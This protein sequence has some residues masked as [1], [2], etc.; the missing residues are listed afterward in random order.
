MNVK[1]IINEEI[2][3]FTTALSEEV[4][5]DNFW[6]WFRNSKIVDKSGKPLIMHHGGSFNPSK[7]KEYM[8]PVGNEFRGIAWFTSQ[9][10]DAR[11][12]AKQ[13]NG[14]ITSVYISIQNP[15]YAG[16]QKDGSYI[17]TNKAVLIAKK[18]NG[19][20]DGVIDALDNGDILDAIV[21]NSTQIKSAKDNNG[22][23]SSTNPDV[24]K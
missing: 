13:N 7:P 20:Y 6:K 21:W 9:K 23:Y 4:L 24:L 11:R 12:Y 5:N 8:T 10:G 15:L 1:V 3:T 17:E 19:E 18:S 16:K 14:N 22:E 2:E